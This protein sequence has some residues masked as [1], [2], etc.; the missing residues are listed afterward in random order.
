MQLVQK[1]YQYCVIST[2]ILKTSRAIKPSVKLKDLTTNQCLFSNLE[3]VC[4][5]QKCGNC[6]FQ[7]LFGVQNVKHSDFILPNFNI[8]RLNKLLVDYCC[9]QQCK[10]ADSGQL[11]FCACF[12][13]DPDAFFY[14]KQETLQNIINN[15]QVNPFL[16][17]V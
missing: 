1:F 13:E 14:T 15:L 16:S 9:L 11:L 2:F 3:K 7:I 17:L 8:T 4:E 6:L 5:G 10:V 12:V